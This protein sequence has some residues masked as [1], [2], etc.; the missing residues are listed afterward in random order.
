MAATVLSSERAFVRLRDMIAAN[1]AL[2]AKLE[3]LEQRLATHDQVIGEIIQAVRDL[4]AAPE[5]ARKRRI[6]FI[7]SD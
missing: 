4:A 1:K 6:A 7:Q 3:E 2:A 5:P